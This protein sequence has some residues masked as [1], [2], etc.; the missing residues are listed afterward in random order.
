MKTAFL[1]GEIEENIYMDQSEGF[2]DG[3]DRVCKLHKSLYGIRQFPR[4]WNNK[5][6]NVMSNLGLQQSVVDSCMFYHVSDTMKLIV[7][8]YVDDGLVI[9]TSKLIISKLLNNLED[10]FKIIVES[11]D[12]FLNISISHQD[13]G[14]IFI[15]QKRYA[16]SIL[17]RF[18]MEDVNPV[19]TAI[20]KCQL[21]QMEIN[22]ELMDIPYR[23]AVGSL[24][25]L[26]VATRPDIAYA[27]NYASH[28]HMFSY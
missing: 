15:S 7:V 9:A 8:L 12:S 4:C 13:N 1:N 19:S 20:E 26:A 22:K 5:F 14:S 28:I 27:V 16:E 25:Y 17:K 18:H 21:L 3:S 10:K 24:M 23:E 2:V 6:K 11:P